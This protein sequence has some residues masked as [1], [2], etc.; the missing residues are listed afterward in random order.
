MRKYD[1]ASITMTSLMLLSVLF[2]PSFAIVMENRIAKMQHLGMFDA[3]GGFSWILIAL[4]VILLALCFFKKDSENR[5]FITGTLASTIMGLVIFLW[6]HAVHILMEGRPTSYRV[7]FGF[8]LFIALICMYAVT[9]KCNQYIKKAWKQGIVSFLGIA[10]IVACFASGW[11][12]KASIMTEY[13]TR[14]E[15]FKTALWEHLSISFVVLVV[16]IAIG[17]PFGYLC[18]KNKVVNA[19]FTACINVIRSLPSIALITVMVTPLS[20]LKNIPILAKLGVGAFGFTPV[21]CAL[22]F[23][24]LFQIVNSLNGALKTINPDLIKAGKAMGMTDR[25]IMAKVQIP[26]ILPVFI[27]GVRVALISTFTAASLGT[28]VGFG[29]LGNIIRLASGNAIAIDMVLLGAVPIMI[30]IF[31]A[32]FVLTRVGKLLEKN[33]AG[34]SLVEDNVVEESLA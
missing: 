10:M 7:T 26:M 21:F 13:F 4:L 24:A 8:A 18:Y 5:N 19:V 15:V 20:M 30:L 1:I 12:N 3:I 32:D 33:L 11:L 16:S 17:I 2:I 34:V 23:Y 9:V 29:G 6:G 25:M 28:L 14:S 27:S 22:F 31:I